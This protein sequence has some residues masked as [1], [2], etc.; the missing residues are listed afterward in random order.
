MASMSDIR[1]RIKSIKDTMQITKA[2]NLIASS[3]MQKARKQLNDTLPY[4][5]KIQAT[6][7]DI[8]AHSTGI[9]THKYFDK[10]DSSSGPRKIGYVIITADKGLCGSYNHNVIKLAEETMKHHSEIQH[11]EQF[12][13]VIGQ[14]GRDYFIRKNYNIDVEFLYTAQSPTFYRARE[15]GELLISLFEQQ[16]LDEIY[17]IYT[18]IK[19]AIKQ[20]PEI[21]KVLPLEKS[22]FDIPLEP[23]ERY[24]E[25][26]EYSPS[27]EKVMDILVP[28]YVKGL[29]FGALVESFCSEQSARMLAMDSAT[30]SAKEMIKQLTLLYNHARQAAITQE[31][32]EIVGGSRIFQ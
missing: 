4:F 30:N 26:L 12:L 21:I 1:S 14:M 19:S 5:E 16:M 28:G 29:I 32:S 24:K 11:T 23:G 3:K 10:R 25:Y 7:K 22:E 8:I 13:F 18:H 27:P 15:I 6:M 31:I 17:I 2:M 20:Q 9:E